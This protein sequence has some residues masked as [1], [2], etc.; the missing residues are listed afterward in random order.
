[1][2][3][4]KLLLHWRENVVTIVFFGWL[5]IY[6]WILYYQWGNFS[7][8]RGMERWQKISIYFSLIDCLGKPTPDLLLSCQCSLTGSNRVYGNY[9]S[10]NNNYPCHHNKNSWDCGGWTPAIPSNNSGT[11]TC[12]QPTCMVR[13]DPPPLP[14]YFARGL[15]WPDR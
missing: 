4:Q 11:D 6:A 1:M 2:M 15:S 8:W 9:K 7:L 10:D 5:R 13:E 3:S 14:C 12:H